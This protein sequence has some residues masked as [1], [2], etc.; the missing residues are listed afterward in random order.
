MYG[1][2]AIFPNDETVP[3]QNHVSSKIKLKKF[4]RISAIET[5]L[6]ENWDL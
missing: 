1:T 2:F 4:K 3:L 5:I 6:N